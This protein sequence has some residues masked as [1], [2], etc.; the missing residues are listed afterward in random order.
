M[1][2]HITASFSRDAL[3]TLP[4]VSALH[5]NDCWYI[6]HHL[7]TMG[8]QFSDHLPNKEM[9][10]PLTFVHQVPMIRQLGEWLTG[11]DISH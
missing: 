6:A 5:Y 2:I 3:T 9:E 10:V 8:H 11:Y 4:Q 1:V 7:L